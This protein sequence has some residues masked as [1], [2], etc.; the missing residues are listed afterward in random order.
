MAELILSLCDL[1]EAEGR[2][3]RKNAQRLG[4]SCALWAV[5]FIFLTLALFFATA[6]I[7]E[8]LTIW[9]PRGLVF[10][11]MAFVTG[12]IALGFFG[13]VQRGSLKERKADER[14]TKPKRHPVPRAE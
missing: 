10:L 8:L 14:G 4:K 3:L 7:Y 1:V 13:L 11:G 5:V 12:V 6:A 9:L 2:V